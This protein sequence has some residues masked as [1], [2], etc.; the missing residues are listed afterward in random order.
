MGYT[1]E[2]H[3][4]Y[5]TFGQ[6]RAFDGVDLAI[7]PGS[8]FA[9][10]GPNGAGKTTLVNILTTLVRPD[11]GS[12]TVAGHD[13]FTDEI[14]VKRSISLTGQFT[15]I[16][17]KL[18]ARENLEMVGQLLHFRAGW[19]GS[20]QVG[21]AERVRSLGGSGPPHRD[22]L[23]RYETAPRPGYGHGQQTCRA[24]PRRADHG[25]RPA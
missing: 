9:L 17:E 24:V 2:A 21:L 16:D 18:T 11:S 3:G 13:I 20:G 7:E 4:L 22:L 12:A 25:A 15:A 6:H 5:K 19:Q 1:V 8:A 23:R 14:G 10:I